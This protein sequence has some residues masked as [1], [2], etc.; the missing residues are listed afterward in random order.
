M[1]HYLTVLLGIVMS[2]LSYRADA[3]YLITPVSP[4]PNFTFNDLW[5]FTVT[6][7]NPDSYTQFYVTL[8]IFDG[9]NALKVKSNSAVVNFPVGSQYY[10]VTNISALQPFTTS[11]YDA[12]LLQN[13]IASGGNFPPG[14]Y[15][16]VYT[17]LGK[18]ADGD[19]VPL[20]E[21]ASQATV[22]VMWP[23][24]LLSPPDG[25]TIDTQ[26]PLLTWTPAFSSL[27]SAPITYTLKLVEVQSGQNGY[28]AIQANPVH[29]TQNN[30]P[31]TLLVYPPSAQLLDTTKTYAWQ[32]HAEAMGTSLGSSEVWTF[33]FKQKLPVLEV[34]K[35]TYYAI[36]KTKPDAAIFL[37]KDDQLRFTYA[38]DYILSPTEKVKFFIYDEKRNLAY[39]FQHCN[40]CKVARD[41][42]YYIID[43]SGPPNGINIKKDKIYY[44]EVINDKNQKR[45]L[46]FKRI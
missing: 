27:I 9:N 24:M 30:L 31:A 39:D 8:R 6:R 13:A 4:P 38:D 5:H 22:E 10:N 3:Q 44:L 37:A 26:Y 23:P 32:V 41:Q 19:F 20:S 16:F 12:S 17:I 25:D 40:E 35:S 7:S 34:R 33:R 18:T 21:D 46:K 11:F 36:L 43:I 14:S 45:V 42:K 2:T 1:K 28:Q 15:N 29:F